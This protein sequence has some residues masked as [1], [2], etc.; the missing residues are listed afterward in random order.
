M[1]TPDQIRQIFPQCPNPEVWAPAIATAWERFGFST[2]LERA[3]F[4]GII[5]NETGGLQSVRREN[6]NYSYSRAAQVWPG[7]AGAIMADRC[8]KGPEAFANWIYAGIIGNGDEASGDGWRFRGGG[9]IQLTGRA[10]F[11]AA[12]VGVGV[13]LTA[14]PDAVTEPGISALVAAWFMAKYVSIL[15][16]LDSPDEAS[17]LAGARKVGLPADDQATV[18]RLAYRRKALE[19]L[20]APIAE[21][22]RPI[23]EPAPAPSPPPEPLPQ[24]SAPQKPLRKSRT[25]WTQVLNW[26]SGLATVTGG[27]SLS[28]MADNIGPAQALINFWKANQDILIVVG[29]L[30]MLLSLVQF[31]IKLNERKQEREAQ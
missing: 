24:A 12:G 4:L 1:I 9:I 28:G 14:N 26:L 7:K 6:M 25:V 21:P 8:S 29:G 13:N 11:T 19:V 27:L 17:F 31:M 20:Q 15:P 2:P 23:P 18:R 22:A 16:L 3:G 10:N 30:A 5:G